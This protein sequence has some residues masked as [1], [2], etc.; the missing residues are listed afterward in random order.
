MSL[1]KFEAYDAV[2]RFL[3]L[4]ATVAT[5]KLILDLR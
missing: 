1:K 4:N 3:D 5:I 2:L